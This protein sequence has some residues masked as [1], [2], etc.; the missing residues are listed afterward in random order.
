MAN[1]DGDVGIEIHFCE[2]HIAR[3]NLVNTCKRIA[4]KIEFDSMLCEAVDGFSHIYQAICKSEDIELDPFLKDAICE[5]MRPMATLD[6]NLTLD[7][8][9]A[10]PKNQTMSNIDIIFPSLRIPPEFVY[11][12]GELVLNPLR[13]LPGAK[14]QALNRVMETAL[15]RFGIWDLNAFTGSGILNNLRD[16]V[17]AVIGNFRFDL[18]EYNLHVDEKELLCENGNVRYR[19]PSESCWH[20]IDGSGIPHDQS[21]YNCKPDTCNECAPSVFPHHKEFR[22]RRNVWKRDHGEIN[23]EELE[24]EFPKVSNG[25]ISWGGRFQR[26]Y[27]CDSGFESKAG[28][29]W[30]SCEHLS[31]GTATDL[32]DCE[33]TEPCSFKATIDN[34]KRIFEND[35]TARY[36]CDDFHY[37]Y[38]MFAR[39]Y[40]GHAQDYPQCLSFNQYCMFPDSIAHGY[41]A[42]IQDNR[43]RYQCNEGAHLDGDPWFACMDY[44][45]K[46]E[47]CRS[48]GGDGDCNFPQNIMNGYLADVNG[49]NARYQCYE[50]YHAHGSDWFSCHDDRDKDE[51]CQPNDGG[52]HSCDFPD[53]IKNGYLKEKYGIEAR[54]ECN[55]GYH[56][57]GSDWFSCH[58]ER[59]KD[60]LCQNDKKGCE[61]PKFIHGGKKILDGPKW[62]FYECYPGFLPVTEVERPGQAACINGTVILPK[63]YIPEKGCAFPQTIP[64]G[65]AVS[66]SEDGATYE[67]HEDKVLMPTIHGN[68]ALCREDGSMSLPYCIPREEAYSLE[69][70]LENSYVLMKLKKADEESDWM[71]VCDDEF[72]DYAAGAVCRHLR[73]GKHGRVINSMMKLKK[74]PKADI[75]YT[76]VS[77]NY[78]DTLFYDM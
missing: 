21:R 54:Y 42:E 63:C 8:C 20:E 47:L 35:T 12:A 32:L 14:P 74:P 15:M 59:D 38:N 10:L 71:T 52:D 48:D 33:K 53:E 40:D 16:L 34:G 29:G 7:Q 11:L 76:H 13:N 18:F 73:Q 39:C 45:N 56:A 66:L 67:C 78:D 68:E 5:F 60:E 41:R 28:H 57:H 37:Q 31:K 36:Q 2:A 62:A 27:S 9:K 6:E 30:V 50:E 55:E 51:L 64:G 23:L 17:M 61:F 24:C 70:K 1:L 46:D 58:D 72:N 19:C 43:A 25:H 69:F 44:R 49:S 4:E 65:I 77:C 26:V 3:V 22:M 75:G